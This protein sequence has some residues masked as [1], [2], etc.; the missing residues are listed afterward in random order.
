MKPYTKDI[1]RTVA[2]KLALLFLLWY[3][4]VKDMHPNLSSSTEWLFGKT[5]QQVLTP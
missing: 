4:C 1:L 2:V 5:E 3:F